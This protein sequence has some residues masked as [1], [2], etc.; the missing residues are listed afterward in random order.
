MLKEEGPFHEDA[1]GEFSSRPTVL[2]CASS[3]GIKVHEV[4][5][6]HKESSETSKSMEL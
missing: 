1:E 3:H 2:V 5:R 4:K 6:R